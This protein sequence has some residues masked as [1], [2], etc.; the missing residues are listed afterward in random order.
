MNL[1]VES[2]ITA[3]GYKGMADFGPYSYAAPCTI[4]ANITYPPEIS[5]RMSLPVIF[6]MSMTNVLISNLSAWP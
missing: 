4:T 3:S 5:L 1:K 6:L 2:K